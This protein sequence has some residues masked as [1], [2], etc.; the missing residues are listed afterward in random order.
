ME[1]KNRPNPTELGCQSRPY[2]PGKLVIAT[3]GTLPVPR[4]SVNAA[5]R[6]RSGGQSPS[7]GQKKSTWI[8]N[9]E[10][11]AHGKLISALRLETHGQI[12][13][14]SQ[15]FQ[16]LSYR[17]SICNIISLHPQYTS[18]ANICHPSMTEAGFPDP[19][20]FGSRVAA[21][22]PA[23]PWFDLW[24]NTNQYHELSIVDYYTTN[25]T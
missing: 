5:G 13:I 15:S 23:S 25:S 20:F 16:A 22:R 19:L 7:R 24:L 6:Y 10:P 21:S 4:L 3:L 14:A 11:A 17:V 1:T 2:S 12:P 18:S 9:H 8:L